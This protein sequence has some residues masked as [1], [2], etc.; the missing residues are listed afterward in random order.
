[1]ALRRAGGAFAALEAGRRGANWLLQPEHVQEA[2]VRQLPQQAAAQINKQ[3]PGFEKFVDEVVKV[4]GPA[5]QE[6]AVRLFR[7]AKAGSRWALNRIQQFIDNRNHA[8]V[9][10]T[11]NAAREQMRH[12]GIRS[13]VSYPWTRKTVS[14]RMYGKRF[15]K[16]KKRYS[17]AKAWTRSMPRGVPSRLNIAPIRRRFIGPTVP[18][19]TKAAR[20][21]GSRPR[22]LFRRPPWRGQRGRDLFLTRNR[23]TPWRRS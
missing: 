12:H 4:H 5:A 11:G 20:F 7:Q 13:R 15:S 8:A 3:L 19:R 1:M 17:N 2:A 18:W 16:K 9:F 14:T 10:A 6:E 23:F 22:V 21:W